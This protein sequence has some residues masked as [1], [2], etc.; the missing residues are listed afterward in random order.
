MGKGRKHKRSKTSEAAIMETGLRIA[1]TM[2]DGDIRS[3]RVAGTQNKYWVPSSSHP[4][5]KYCVHLT[6]SDRRN[7]C[8]CIAHER[9]QRPCKHVA[10]L[11]LALESL[12]SS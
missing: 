6:P 12:R 4:G 1:Q 7:F 3:L 10:A 11:K 8:E 9:R 2:V 5:H